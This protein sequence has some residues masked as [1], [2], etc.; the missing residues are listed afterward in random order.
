MKKYLLSLLTFL[1]FLISSFLFMKLIRNKVWCTKLKLTVSLSLISLSLW[2][3][4][5]IHTFNTSNT[6]VV[7]AGITDMNVKAWGGGGSGGGASGAGLLSGRGGAGGGGGAYATSQIT[8]V[9]G[10]T[11]NVIVAGQT[12]G[13]TGNGTAGGNSTIVTFE[14]TI[15]A[16]GGAGG[17]ANTTGAVPTGGAGG[18]ALASFGTTKVDGGNG[19]NGDVALLSAGLNSGSGGN[20]GLPGGGNGGSGISSGIL[21]NG[22]GN[23]GAAPGGGGGGA[24][25]AALGAAQLGG[26]GAAG[27]VIISYT[28]PTYGI[29]GV[30]ATAVCTT[31]G[32]ST[33]TLT[34]SAASL[35]IGVY[36]VTY[37]L[38]NPVQ[39]NLSIAMT[40]AT[41]GQGTFPLTGL[42]AI[43]TRNITIIKLTSE[44]CI[45]NISLNNSASIVT[46]AVTAGGTIDGSTAVCYGSTSGTLSLT[47]NVGSVLNWESS[48]SPFS[49]WTPIVNTATSYVSG[50]LTETTRFRAVVQ[51]GG[52]SVVNSAEISVAI[53]P[54]PQGS[55]SAN[56]PFCGTGSP[57]LTF[58]ATQG[59]GP[60]T[61]VYK[62]NGGADRTAT[63]VISGTPFVPFTSSINSSTTYTLVSVTGAN[64]CLR[65][66]GFTG[67][68]ASV[69]VETKPS[70]PILGTIVQPTCVTSTGSVVLNGLIAAVNWTITQ[71]N[72]T[73]FQTYSGSGTTFT[74]LN[75]APG[76]YTFTIHEN[77]SCISLPTVN[78]QINAPI[79]NIWNGALW[80]KGSPPISTDAIEFTGNYQTSGDLAGCSCVVNLGVNVTVNSNHTLTI[81]NFVSNT[82]GIL[83]FE[84]NASLIQINNSVNTGNINYK[85]TSKQ[86]LQADFVYWST[87]V[88]PQKLV[89]V[90]QFTESDKYFRFNGTSWVATD[91]NTNMTVG[92]GYIIRGPETYSNTIRA[93]YTAS[94]IGVPNNGNVTSEA[95]DSGKYYLLGNPYPSAVDADQFITD[96][97]ILQGTLY[98]W[99]HNTPVILGGYYRYNVNDYASYN[100]TGVVVTKKAALAPGYNNQAPDGK[101]AAGQG[102]FA[103]I[104]LP[105]TITFTN[106]MRFGANNQFFKP[107]KTSKPA[108]VEKNRLWL[109]LSN[110][111]GA[112]KQ[113]LIGYIGGATNDIERG[114]D[115]VTFDSNKYLDFYSVNNGKKLVIQ[116]RAVPFLDTDTVPLGYKSA[117]AG[118]FTISIDYAD[119]NMINQPVYLEDKVTSSIHNLRS[120]DYTF[121]TGIGS[122]DDRF[123]LHYTNKSLGITDIED[124]EQTVLVSVKEKIIKVTS[125]KENMSEVSVFDVTGKLLFNKNK[126]NATKL[127]ISNL[128][129]GSQVLLVKTTLENQYTSTTKIVF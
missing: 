68:S 67:G 72:G 12:N 18:K 4:S 123:V 85:R 105:G 128:Q 2:A 117:I 32:T 74:V 22:P 46:S 95:L 11:L 83:T 51:S 53:N 80:S 49:T 5:P 39:N 79:T 76:N 24:I 28:C 27:Q 33:I 111:E 75:L 60:Y 122:F 9:A 116:G 125:T 126:I 31:A 17:G 54:L 14:N 101:I 36:T 119:G 121:S 87:P 45:S 63:S 35:P 77:A 107:A 15:Q 29:S 110:T 23:P 41:A 120:S 96:N 26:R 104:S 21:Q 99:T 100:L 55:L 94:F 47:G 91:R 71:S 103:G 115:G 106:A 89:D 42:N 50:P 20:G 37:N 34:G 113:T 30:T 6:L 129:S 78:V 10:I 73:V 61:I 124:M 66:N 97:P 118:D 62:E 69:T 84:N 57:Q 93:D 65:P 81:T 98:F 109:N 58:T 38:T 25:N 43:G 52:C 40:I 64:T 108:I 70:A 56:G 114:Y 90:S 16:A 44:D 59:T 48:V 102:F 19:G 13:T 8:V 1:P 82:G 112:F 3:Q 92:K 86:I 88:N 7:P 127:Q